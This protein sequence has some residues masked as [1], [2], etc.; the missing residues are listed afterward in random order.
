MAVRMKP[1][2]FCPRFVVG[3]QEL[4]HVVIMKGVLP[5]VPLCRHVWFLHRKGLRS[6][7]E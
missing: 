6:G 7:K 4:A 3:T 5:E 1:T 2:L